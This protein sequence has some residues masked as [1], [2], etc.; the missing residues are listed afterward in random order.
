MIAAQRRA[1]ILEHLRKAG[2]DSII[3]LAASIGMSPST[4][5]R[6]LDFLMQ[7][8]HIVRSHGGGSTSR[9]R[10]GFGVCCLNINEVKYVFRGRPSH[11]LQSWNGRNALEAAVMFYTA[12]DR[13]R[14][15][16]RPERCTSRPASSSP[17]TCRV[18]GSPGRISR[19]W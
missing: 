1:L 2:G 7:G 16:L 9:A 8:G 5:R 14:S 4:I 6:D 17:G 10:A 11:Q 19:C 15:S 18:T 13:L 3:D 12:V